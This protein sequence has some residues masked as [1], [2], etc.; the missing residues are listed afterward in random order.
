MFWAHKLFIVQYLQWMV[1]RYAICNT[2]SMNSQL[3]W[4]ELGWAFAK[5]PKKEGRKKRGM[6][7]G[8]KLRYANQRMSK[9]MYLSTYACWYPVRVQRCHDNE[10]NYEITASFITHN[11]TLFCAIG[12]KQ[13]WIMEV[14]GEFDAL[15]LEWL[16]VIDWFPRV[17]MLTSL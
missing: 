13:L 11:S 8:M 7:G 15:M 4:A 16:K 2:R 10:L 14:R 9:C 5:C 6:D 3:S 12:R 17:G 1:W